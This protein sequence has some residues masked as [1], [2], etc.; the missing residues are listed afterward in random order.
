MASIPLG[1]TSCLARNIA[2]TVGKEPSEQH[3]KLA[4]G[5]RNG[6]PESEISD[7][8]QSALNPPWPKSGVGVNGPGGLS[9]LLVRQVGS[10]SV[11]WSAPPTSSFREV[12]AQPGLNP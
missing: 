9:T 5:W 6:P 7:L 2:A 4:N 11:S 12:R 3:H 8:R 10:G 1:P